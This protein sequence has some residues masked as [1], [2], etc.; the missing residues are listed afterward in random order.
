MWYNQ[1]MA[2]NGFIEHDVS[3][4]PFMGL[5]I[6]TPGLTVKIF[7]AYKADGG[8]TAGELSR[9]LIKMT[10]DLQQT[11][12]KLVE[13]RQDLDGILKPQGRPDESHA[14][15]RPPQRPRGPRP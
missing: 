6:D 3:G 15:R 8:A 9:Q 5:L 13:V 11:P 4:K 12:D 2:I 10:K 1:G 7:L 14:P